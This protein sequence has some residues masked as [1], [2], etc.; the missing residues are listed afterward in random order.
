[1]K[2]PIISPSLDDA[3]NK[4]NVNSSNKKQA[5]VVNSENQRGPVDVEVGS[6]QEDEG[7]WVT[8]GG[9]QVNS[10]NRNKA[11]G[12]TSN[13]NTQEVSTTSNRKTGSDKRTVPTSTNNNPSSSAKKTENDI[14]LS[15]VSSVPAASVT[16]TPEPIEICQLLPA[17]ED[18]YTAS[19]N[20]WKQALNK[21]QT[22]SVDD[23][24]EWPEREQEEQYTVQKRIIP[25]KAKALTEK[26]I[27]IDGNDEINTYKNGRED[28]VK[29]ITRLTLSKRIFF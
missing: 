19:D 12:E 22:F 10:R 29:K 3:T 15:E 20:W 24:G 5:V 6:D 4:V 28:E 18:R 11:K 7:Q 2:N 25:V 26:D 8:Q 9:K 27:N 14:D 1:M 17:G 21:Q 13:A 23:I 16:P